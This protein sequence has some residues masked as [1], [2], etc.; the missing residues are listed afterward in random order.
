MNLHLLFTK[1]NFFREMR[2]LKPSLGRSVSALDETS[3]DWRSESFSRPEGRLLT[4]F[5]AILILVSFERLAKEGMLVSLLFVTSRISRLVRA[6]NA[7]RGERFS[8]PEPSWFASRLRW[9]SSLHALMPSLSFVILLLLKSAYSNL[10]RYLSSEGMSLSWL[11]DTF[12][13]W[14]FVSAWNTLEREVILLKQRFSRWSL[15]SADIS[16]TDF[17]LQLPS[18]SSR[19]STR[20][21][22]VL[23]RLVKSWLIS[24]SCC[25]IF[26]HVKFAGKTGSR[27]AW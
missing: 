1:A 8:T 4:W 20:F 22:I 26:S 12:R 6:V 18:V 15:E 2:P 11:L 17:S 24:S 7:E 21:D 27:P 3:K 16:L 14:R 10:V 25:S 5:S 23:G 9:V 13:L 19:S